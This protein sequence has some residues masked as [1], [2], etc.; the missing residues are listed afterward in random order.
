M[1]YLFF[2]IG[3]GIFL[4]LHIYQHS[5]IRDLVQRFHFYLGCCFPIVSWTQLV[6]GGITGL[7]ICFGTHTGQCVSHMLVGSAF[8]FHGIFLL[9]MIH[10]GQ[11][12]L[13]RRGLSQEFLDSCVLTGW[14]VVKTFTEHGL[15]FSGGKVWSHRDTQNTV[16]G[17]FWAITGSLGIYLSRGRRRSII[18]AFIII[19]TGWTLS[20]HE[21]SS[22]Y[23]N[24]VHDVFG[25][26]LMAAG[27]SKLSDVYFPDHHNTVSRIHLTPFLLT[28]SGVMFLSATDQQL[29]IILVKQIDHPTYAL[30]QI[31]VSAIIYFFVNLLIS[32][33][34]SKDSLND[35][36]SVEYTALES[37]D[38]ENTDSPL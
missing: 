16:L 13:S 1:W 38:K 20:S 27:L 25:Y 23:S 14:G 37:F 35:Q 19:V 21:Q 26:T 9:L 4:K 28:V 31:S 36:S 12:W 30:I 7:R 6:L 11:P 29:R 32:L 17:I 10:F 18:P 5:G 24:L 8:V 22:P 34:G 3:C 15:F 33:Y 2:Q